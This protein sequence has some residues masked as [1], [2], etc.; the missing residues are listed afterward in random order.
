MKSGI[1]FLLIYFF[2]STASAQI[3]NPSFEDWNAFDPVNWSTFDDVGGIDGI[4]ESSDA[5][6]GSSSVRMEVV[7]L[8]GFAFPPY[9]WSIDDNGNYH[10]VSQ[11]HGSFKGWYKFSPQGNDQLYIVVGMLD[12]DS[13]VV[14]AGAFSYLSA[15]SSWTEFDIPIYYNPGTPD[16]VQTFISIGIYDSTGQTTAGSFALIDHLSFTDPSAVEQIG[17]MPE[18]FSLSQNYPNPFNPTTNIEY[19]IP[20]ASFVQLKVYDILG[21]EVATLVNE[22]QS[23]GTYRADFTANNLA[24]GFYVAQLRAENYTKTIKM[25]LMK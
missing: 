10:P 22:E 25:T 2:F 8:G 17:G 4:T 15:V 23:A 24:S 18:D 21:N 1:T 12:T 6:E 14:G 3:L 9:L 19:T 13:S 11:K 5:H 20:E 7:D 16:P